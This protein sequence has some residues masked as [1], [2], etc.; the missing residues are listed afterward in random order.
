[1]K[2]LV[3]FF[4]SLL[5]ASWVLSTAQAQTTFSGY[6]GDTP[7]EGTQRDRVF[8]F[9]HGLSSKGNDNSVSTWTSRDGTFWP[10]K[11]KDDPLFQD[12]DVFVAN[13]ETGAWENDSFEAVADGLRNH[14][15]NEVARRHSEIYFVA[16]S[17][18]GIALRRA[19]L[20]SNA[21]QEKTKALFLFAVPNGGAALANLARWAP[22]TGPLVEALRRSDGDDDSPLT[23]VKSEWINRDLEIPSYCG[24]E[25]KSLGIIEGVVVPRESVEPLCTDGISALSRNHETIVQPN[26]EATHRELADP[27]LLV[28]NWYQNALEEQGYVSGIERFDQRDVAIASCRGDRDYSLLTI[29]NRR[30]IVRTSIGNKTFGVTK[31]MPTRWLYSDYTNYLWRNNP[32][33]WVVIHYSCFERSDGA[34]SSITKRDENFIKFAK[35]MLT[36]GVNILTFSRTFLLV[37]DRRRYICGKFMRSQ[38][39]EE[40]NENARIFM[41]PVISGNVI[42]GSDRKVNERFGQAV[43]DV[44][45]IGSKEFLVDTMCAEANRN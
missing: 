39:L 28:K 35:D 16:H 32:P 5:V 21:L 6:I 38:L 13:Y 2:Q 42:G 29:E 45:V 3:A 27:H 30:G 40:Q 33:K 25:T 26:K 20:D 22:K 12:S 31:P 4:I 36:N 1:M 14:L 9:I 15:L 10:Q 41:Y 44:V 43:H 18:G 7:S 19:I 34:T 8:V 23:R 37:D 11:L 24:F 17:L